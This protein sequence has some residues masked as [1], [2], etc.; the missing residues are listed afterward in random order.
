MYVAAEYFETGERRVRLTGEGY[1]K[2]KRDTGRPFY[3]ET[4]RLN[5]RVLGTEFNLSAYKDD[6]MPSATLINGAVR[7]IE[8]RGD[9]VMLKPADERKI[10]VPSLPGRDKR[11]HHSPPFFGT[12]HLRYICPVN[13]HERYRGSLVLRSGDGRGNRIVRFTGRFDHDRPADGITRCIFMAVFFI[14]KSP[15]LVIRKHCIRI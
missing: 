7:V 9:S 5:V 8:C 11:N 2:V 3:V 1:F 4:E 14:H 6:L 15:I 12:D 10:L 13:F